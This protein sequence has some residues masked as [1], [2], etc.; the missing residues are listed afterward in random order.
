MDLSIEM[1]EALDQFFNWRLVNVPE[2][3]HPVLIILEYSPNDDQHPLSIAFDYSGGPKCWLSKSKVRKIGDNSPKPHADYR[4]FVFNERK[5]YPYS[6]K[7]LPKTIFNNIEEFMS[8]CRLL[9][10]HIEWS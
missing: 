5:F 10:Q 4:N 7:A 6:I 9:Y 8:V 1:N 3:E 2:L